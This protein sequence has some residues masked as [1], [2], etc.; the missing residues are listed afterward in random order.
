MSILTL[1]INL[2]NDTTLNSIKELTIDAN[3]N[4]SGLMKINY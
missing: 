2:V 1:I 3:A 4:A